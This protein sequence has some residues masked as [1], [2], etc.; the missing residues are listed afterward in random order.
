[1]YEFKGL[2]IALTR[3]DSLVIGINLTGRDVP[4]GMT[5]LFT[6]KQTVRSTDAVIE[7]RVAVR[8]NQALIELTPADTELAPRT[9]FWDFRLIGGE[10]GGPTLVR[11]PM[12]YAAFQILEVVG[13]AG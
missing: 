6:V 5:G 2:D 12:E 10:P 7:K 4:P 9:Y 11:T 3:G 13:N 1:M 8:N